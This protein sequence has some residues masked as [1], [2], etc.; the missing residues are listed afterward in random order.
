MFDKTRPNFLL[1]K[2]F[3]VVLFSLS[4]LKQNQGVS[5]FIFCVIATNILGKVELSLPYRLLTKNVSAS[6]EALQ[7]VVSITGQLCVEQKGVFQL[8]F[9]FFSIT[10][11]SAIFQQGSSKL[12]HLLRCSLITYI[13]QPQTYSVFFFGGLEAETELSVPGVDKLLLYMMP[14]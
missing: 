5:E 11:Y 12:T 1:V 7:S 4:V 14:L 3:F 2:W 10:R 9:F 6:C 13:G 8:D